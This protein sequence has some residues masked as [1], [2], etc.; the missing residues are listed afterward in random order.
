VV[1]VLVMAGVA[2]YGVQGMDWIAGMGQVNVVEFSAALHGDPSWSS[3]TGKRG[4][5]WRGL[6]DCDLRPGQ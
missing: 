1:A 2:P 4:A 3:A 6:Q 5:A